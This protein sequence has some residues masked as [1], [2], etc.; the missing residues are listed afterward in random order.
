MK[1]RKIIFYDLETNGLSSSLD[2]R[3][4]VYLAKYNFEKG[5]AKFEKEFHSLVKIDNNHVDRYAF[6]KNG[7]TDEFMNTNGRPMEEVMIDTAQMLNE[8]QES[9]LCGYVI[10]TFDNHFL[11]KMWKRYAFTPFDFDSRTFDLA[12]EYKAT[13][14]GLYERFDREDWRSVHNMVL[15][16]DYSHYIKLT[17]YGLKTE[18]CCAY[19]GIPVEEGQQHNARYDTN[20]NIEILKKQRPEWFAPIVKP[21]T[22]KK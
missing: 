20:L 7:W 6:K 11:Q 13:L 21:K 4:E 19:Y 17:G 1:P 9:I 16:N 10:K 12:I 22:S 14:A 15:R 2:R 3:L 18:H 5:K 8:D